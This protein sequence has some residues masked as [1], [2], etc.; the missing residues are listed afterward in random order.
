MVKPNTI[1][2]NTIKALILLDSVQ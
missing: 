1:L 2:V